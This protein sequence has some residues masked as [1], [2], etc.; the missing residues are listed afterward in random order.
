MMKCAILCA[1]AAL[2]LLPPPLAVEAQE[3]PDTVRRLDPIIVS[4]TRTGRR[5]ED[6]P[7]RVEVVVR[8]EIEEKLLMTPGDIAML[9]NETGGVRIQAT[10]PALGGAAVRIQ[11]LR[12]RYAQILSDGLPLYG[13]ATGLGPLQIPPMDLAQVEVIKGAASALYGAAALGG[14]VNLISRRPD[15]DSELLFNV[16]SRGGVDAVGY[17]STAEAARGFTL[18]WGV[19]TQGRRDLDGDDWFDMPHYDRKTV[20]PRLFLG[21]ERSPVMITAGFTQEE[22]TGGG[23]VAAARMGLDTRRLD[24]GIVGGTWLG[25]LRLSVRGSAM[26]QR[27]EHTFG[28]SSESDRHGSV[29]GEA[30]LSGARGAHTWLVGVAVQ[31]D[32]YANDD[33]AGFDDT[34]TSPGV[35]VQDEW[36]VAPWLSLS[37]SARADRSR[38]DVLVSPRLSVLF[39]PGEWSV[40]AAAGTGHHLPTHWI[41]EIDAIGL[42]AL[43]Q[44]T[45]LAVER[46]RAASLDVGRE[47]GPV[48]L[49]VTGFASIIED[50]VALRGLGGGALF[51]ANVPG[52]TRTWGGEALA[53]LH[54]EGV[55][56]S[57]SYTYL[58]ATEPEPDT[59]GRREVT[60]TPRHSAGLVVAREWEDVGR[61][62]AEAY[63]TGRQQ[64][65]DNPYRATSAPYMVFGVLA[66][67]I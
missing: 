52:Q 59:R 34:A 42:G 10:A 6:E 43:S 4:S 11:G 27:H 23:R 60:L 7:V 21:S 36:V 39:R 18:M 29:F 14:V 63:Y 33:V 62:G 32:S 25:A 45:E 57:L 9:L 61:I 26:G 12:G 56:A 40:R 16:T 24:A 28:T 37:A 17:G 1:C 38:D 5:I 3:P 58:R 48:E 55:H 22:R 2:L 19:H 13:E 41:E 64:L 31:H 50:A 53:R 15:G 30:A 54:A 51:V 35:F 67:R 66:E 65:E 49:N 46:A 8:E 44:T 47:V 20:R